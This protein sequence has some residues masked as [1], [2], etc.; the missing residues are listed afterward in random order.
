MPSFPRALVT[1]SSG[2]VGSHVVDR[3]VEAGYAVTGL[4]RVPPR[5]ELPAGVDTIEIDIRHRAALEAAVLAVRP[6]IV[7]HLA[8]QT[9]VSVSMREPVEDIETN[10][11]GTV[12]L[13]QAAAAAGA[14]RFV[15]VSTGG[16]LYGQPAILPVTEDMPPAP[17]SVYG[18]SKLAAERYLPLVAPS[19]VTSVVRPGNIYGPRQDPHGEAGVVAIFARR[20]LAEQPVTIF[21][22]G[23][24]QRDYVQVA[25]VTDAILRAAE[26]DPAT[27]L[28]GTG[29][30][31]STMEIYRELAALTGYEAA[32]VMAPARPGDIQ[33]IALDASRAT[34]TWGWRPRIGLTEGLRETVAWFRAHPTT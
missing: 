10:V 3:L 5:H 19:L 2:F 8:A 1:G 15:F 32:P 26:A 30:P 24:P 28:I 16:A 31:T 20:M 34:A 17:E 22:E 12:Y 9:S 29:Q 25:D 23:S 7:L 13:A 27:C 14:Y 11:L 4:D 21:G 6:D 18:A 33:R